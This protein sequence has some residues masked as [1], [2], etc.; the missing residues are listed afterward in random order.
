MSLQSKNLQDIL[1]FN[2]FMSINLAI[3]I[4]H[5]FPQHFRRSLSSHGCEQTR[6]SL[7]MI[8]N[9]EQVDR[10]TGCWLSVLM[11]QNNDIYEYKC[12]KFGTCSEKLI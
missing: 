6:K 1:G 3:F 7:D 9:F 5:L 2:V 8:L 4:I 10:Y 11:N 12:T